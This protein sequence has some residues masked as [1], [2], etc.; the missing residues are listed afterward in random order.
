MSS[1]F[2]YGELLS[3]IVAWIVLSVAITYPNLVGLLMGTG[4]LDTVIAGFVATATGFILHEMGH[5]FV[6]IRRGYLAHFRLWIWAFALTIPIVP[7]SGGG[8]L[9]GSPGSVYF[10]LPAPGLSV[11]VSC[12]ERGSPKGQNRGIR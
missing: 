10:P 3:I 11:Y 2:S 12:R 1:Q 4:S 9:F 5:K 8:L 6:A 7:F